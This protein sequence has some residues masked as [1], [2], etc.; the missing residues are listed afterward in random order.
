MRSPSRAAA[1]VR[2]V[3]V[4]RAAGVS[5]ITVSRAINTPDKLAPATLRAVRAAVASLGYVPNLTAGSLASNRSR[6]AGLIVPTVAD[7]IF[8]DT[9]DGLAATLTAHR[10]QLLL[11][12]SG[13]EDA[14]E[15][16]LVATFLGR[17]VEGLVLT[18]VTHARGVRAR[19]RRARLPVVEVWDLDSRP[20]DTVVG[21]SNVEAGRAAARYLLARGWR[22]LAFVGGT[23]ERSAKRLAGFREAAH[24]AGVTRVRSVLLPPPSS[25]VDGSAALTRLLG[26][27]RPRAVFCSN[28]T[29]A[30]GVVFECVRRRIAVPGALAVM[31]FA[32]LPLAS[33]M[34]PALTSVQVSAG[35]IGRRAGDALLRRLRGDPAAPRVIDVGFRIVQRASA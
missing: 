20:I 11:G 5:A 23:D 28:D 4:A 25:P 21:F 26:E 14:Q 32:D 31:G 16:A 34:V 27:S 18:G 33:A 3:D 19:L 10:Y 2:L 8:S 30:A 15:D 7:S 24:A 17:R 35:E 9:I 12:R 1:A 13:Y 22:D 6:T 29:L